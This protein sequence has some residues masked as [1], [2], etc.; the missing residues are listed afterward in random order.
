MFRG[1]LSEKCNIKGRASPCEPVADA[2]RLCQNSCSGTTRD[3][4]T[5]IV[6]CE[7]ESDLYVGSNIDMCVKCGLV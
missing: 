7:C 5:L 2:E 3:M 1:Q 4:H 6:Q